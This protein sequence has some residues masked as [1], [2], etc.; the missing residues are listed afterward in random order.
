MFHF[1][2]ALLAVFGIPAL[3]A[4]FLALVVPIARFGKRW[5]NP[6]RMRIVMAIA[7]YVLLLVSEF[8][9]FYWASFDR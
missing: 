7:I 6:R 9:L 2:M 1:I 8:L 3:I 4:Y 5:S